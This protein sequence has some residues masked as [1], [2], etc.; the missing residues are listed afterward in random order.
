MTADR[1]TGPLPPL[2][3]LLDRLLDVTVYAPLGL[4]LL[5]REEVPKLAAQGRKQV[6]AR[7]DLA[8]MVGQLA[9]AQ[10]RRQAQ[11]LVERLTGR[12]EQEPDPPTATTRPAREAPPVPPPELETEPGEDEHLPVAVG[13]IVPDLARP[14]SVAVPLPAA[15][16]VTPVADDLPIPGYDSLS[17]SQVV[18][19]L[20]G[21]SP[22][23][24]EAVRAY[25]QSGRARKTVLLRVAQL[26]SASS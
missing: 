20:A 3:R 24:L 25:E 10:G 21:L 9:V 19:R 8:R 15:P 7:A 17:A 16:A 11:G 13:E 5:A 22:D 6:D 23:E 12:A 18:Q 14:T 26:R 4:I 2:D 1:A